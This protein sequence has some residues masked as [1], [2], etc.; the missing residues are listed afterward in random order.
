[1]DEEKAGSR[2]F[3]IERRGAERRTQVHVSVEVT[4]DHGDG[5]PSTER[6]FIEDVS[7]F[8]CRF[9]THMEVHQG[10]TVWLKLVTPAGKKIQDEEARQYQIM[11]VAP[12]GRTFTVGARLIKGEKLI[13]PEPA[14]AATPEQRSK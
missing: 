14:A 3:L 7:D 8:G 2:I 12:K 10:D 1:V 5:H 11:W 6:T 13:D 4:V 9:T